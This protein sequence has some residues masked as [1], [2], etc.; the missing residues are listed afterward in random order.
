MNCAQL[1]ESLGA[2]VL[3]A[4][5]PADAE[6]VRTHLAIC[7]ACV[8]E[9]DQ[10]RSLP[11]LLDLVPVD[12]VTAPLPPRGPLEGD[13]IWE[14][15]VRR[16]EGARSDRR[17]RS[18][19]AAVGAVAA[20][21]L[22]A[23]M[24]GVALRDGSDATV[25]GPSQ[26]PTVG[27][28]VTTETVTARNSKNGVHAAVSFAGVGWGTKL[29]VAVGGVRPGEECSLVA[30]GSDGG[31]E[32]AASWQIPPTG[33]PRDTGMI[34]VPGAVAMHPDKIRHY[35]IVTASGE[36]LLKIPAQA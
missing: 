26:T 32:T 13:R 4:L 14:G 9:Y 19:F 6:Q 18:V 21:G 12:Q 11:P 27:T 15:L 16:A 20:A 10:L 7:P 5:E 31:R 30:V 28:T 23:F 33:Y 34:S 29:T 17:R 22:L 3:G 1:R 24:A 35:E 2:Y 8:E 25:A 36:R